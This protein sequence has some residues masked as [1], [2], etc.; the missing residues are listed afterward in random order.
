M[1]FVY[2]TYFFSIISLILIFSAC[3]KKP[4]VEYT[5]TYKMAGEWYTRYFETGTTAPVDPGYRKITT[6]NTSDPASNQIWVADT[7][8]WPFRSKL[9]VDY[10]NMAFKALATTPNLSLAGK[11]VKVY[12]GKVLARQGHS[13]SGNIVD[14]I[15]LKV[16]FSDDPG[17]V[18]EIRG[19][20][21]TGFF[22]DEY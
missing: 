15:Y 7:L 10:P 5:A 9:D 17:T 3:S 21:R 14:S 4:D 2:K 19:H 1:K 22:E 16:E 13:K 11:T 6:Y 12:E 8:F 20:Q 18:Y